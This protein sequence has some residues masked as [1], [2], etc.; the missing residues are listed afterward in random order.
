MSSA[1]IVTTA[2]PDSTQEQAAALVDLTYLA[3]AGLPSAH[4]RRSYTIGLR[5]FLAWCQRTARYKL[6]PATVDAY[7]AYLRDDLCLPI[8]AR[9][10]RL[11]AVR[12]LATVAKQNGAIDREVALAILDTPLGETKGARTGRWLSRDQAQALLDKTAALR[13]VKGARDTALLAVL[14]GTG[15][16]RQE[17]SALTFAD[18]QQR[19]GRW[20]IVDIIGKGNKRG[21]II[22]DA[23]TKVALDAWAMH[24]RITSGYIFRPV[25]RGT[26]RLVG[27]DSGEARGMSTSAI[28]RAVHE[29]GARIG[30]P[31]LAAHDLRRTFAHLAEQGGASL[32]QIQLALRHARLDTTQKYL[33][34]QLDW[35]DA[36]CDHLGLRLHIV[37]TGAE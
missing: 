7:T 20:A 11:K 31:E 12:R 24:A 5:D 9:V 30:V 1:I 26:G 14:L 21:T 15:L 32:S 25:R 2:Q 35:Q 34:T 19:E 6:T 3:L 29:A 23:W 27:G 36:P 17:A 37:T 16:R 18:V 33:G 4:S 8:P 13:T 28:G 10:Q 22:M